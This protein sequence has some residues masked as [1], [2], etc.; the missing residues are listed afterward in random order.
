MGGGGSPR[1]AGDL[2]NLCLHRG[3]SA[4]DFLTPE[5]RVD[6]EADLEK[7][8][9]EHRFFYT[10]TGG[11]AGAE[12]TVAVL[13]EEELPDEDVVDRFPEDGESL[14]GNKSGIAFLFLRSGSGAPLDHRA[15]LGSILGLGLERRAVG[16]IFPNQ[17]GTGVA[18]KDRL[19]PFL[20]Q[21]LQKV[22]RERAEVSVFFPEK[23]FTIEKKTESLSVLVASLR[24]DCLC[25]SILHI[26][27]EEAGA[28][29]AEGYA[30]IDHR[31][32][33]RPDRKVTAGELL[34]LR[35]KGRFLLTDRQRSTKSGRL[36]V[37]VLHYV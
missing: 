3:F 34:S 35:G 30:Q 26:S 23:N 37:E 32:C 15:V 31:V 11:V 33:K 8:R 10:F 13:S 18:V 29:I 36:A 14:N 12:R 28:Y 21:N 5:E 20:L 9:K 16:D 6:W 7:L 27:R 22:G 1:K 24:L 17:N 25:A 4:G 19:V 2:W